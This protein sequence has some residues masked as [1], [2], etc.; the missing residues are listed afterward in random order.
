MFSVMSAYLFVCLCVCVS[1]CLSDCLS[2]SLSLY[3]QAITF[4]S[5]HIE[6]SFLVCKYIFTIIRSSLSIKVIASRSSS[7]DKE[8]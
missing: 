2:V 8:C 3:F 6:T 1:F 4:E 5:L 7:Y